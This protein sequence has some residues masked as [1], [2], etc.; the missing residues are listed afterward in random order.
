MKPQTFRVQPEAGQ[1][2]I[3]GISRL[4]HGMV[5][6]INPDNG[7]CIYVHIIMYMHVRRFV[8]IIAAYILA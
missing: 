8:F 4:Y 5:S 2:G 7:I 1:K 3:H 6:L